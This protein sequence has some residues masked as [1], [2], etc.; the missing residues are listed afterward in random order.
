M[1]KETGVGRACTIEGLQRAGRAR[2]HRCALM[3][4]SGTAA[5]SVGARPD[6]FAGSSAAGVWT[7]VLLAYVCTRG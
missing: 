4:G 6:A 1:G 3:V 5:K 7:A 2:A